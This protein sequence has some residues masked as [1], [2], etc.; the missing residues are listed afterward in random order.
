MPP[1]TVKT[2]TTTIPIVEPVV[3]PVK[4]EVIDKK[5][6]KEVKKEPVV[7]EEVDNTVDALSLIHI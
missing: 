1:R 3:A 7:V 4:E 5:V 2:K 6:K